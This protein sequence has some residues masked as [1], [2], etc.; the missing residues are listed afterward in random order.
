MPSPAI[1]RAIVADDEGPARRFLVNL[2]R[3]TPGVEVAGEA[4]DGRSALA[5]I[6]EVRPDVAFLDLQMPELGGLDVARML[7]AG[8]APVLAFVTA[9]DEFAEQAFELNAVD[10]LLKPVERERLEST[11]RRA[12]HRLRADEVGRARALQS[13]Q[14][15]FDTATRRPH[16]ERIPVRRRNEVVLLPVRLLASVVAEGELLH[17]TTVQGERYTITY[18]LHALEAR[19]DVRRFVRLARGIL[20]AVD[21]IQRVS[22]LPGGQL[23]VTLV[24]GQQLQASRSQSRVLRDTLLRL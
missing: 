9:F 10:Y 17:L 12:R 3:A 7:Q 22:P 21:A 8:A 24:N 5:L 13:A 14:A 23:Q 6:D 15:A 1:L 19:L 18:R 20:A 11:L 4:R 16:L 2:L